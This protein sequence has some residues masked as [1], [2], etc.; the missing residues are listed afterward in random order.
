LRTI[1]GD[2]SG[3]NTLITGR[4]APTRISRSLVSK[5]AA[6]YCYHH[7]LPSKPSATRTVTGPTESGLKSD[8]INRHISLSQLELGTIIIVNNNFAFKRST[9]KGLSLSIS[10]SDAA[11]LSQTEAKPTN[12]TEALL[13]PLSKT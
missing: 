3:R 9:T 10:V 13:C 12:H 4:F 11:S 1:A 8:K 6:A 2:L 7:T 5:P